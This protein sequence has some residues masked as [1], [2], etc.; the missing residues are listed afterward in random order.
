MSEKDSLIKSK[1][2][3]TGIFNFKELYRV[4][5]EWLVDQNYDVNE[6]SYKEVI[7]AGGAKELEIEWEATKKVSDYFKFEIK[8]VWRI[9]GMTTVEVEID[10]VKDKMNKGQ[11]EIEFKSTLI[12]DYEDKWAKRPTLLFLRTI[13]DKYLVKE[14]TDQY[15]GKLVGEL[16]ELIGQ[17]KSFLALTGKR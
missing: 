7:G 11:L 1:V 2:K 8:A 16:Q 15:Q 12:R 9:V 3:N 13:Y 6:K 17:C 4:L 5:Y 10:G 14:K